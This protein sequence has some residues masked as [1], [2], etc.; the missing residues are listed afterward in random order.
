MG[1]AAA[2]GQPEIDAATRLLAEELTCEM[3][4]EELRATISR[5]AAASLARGAAD[6]R[7]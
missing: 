1:N 3:T 6:R 7:F 4:D 5:A 2:T